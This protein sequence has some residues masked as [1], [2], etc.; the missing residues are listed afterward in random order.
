MSP[1]MVKTNKNALAA[2]PGCR[3]DCPGCPHR[4]MPRQESLNQKQTFLQTRLSTWADRI[5]AICPPDNAPFLYYRKKVCLS[6]LWEVPVWKFGLIRRDAVMD[7]H[8]CPV[9]SHEVRAAIHLFVKSLPHFSAFPLVFYAQSGAQAT[10]V[11]KQQALPDLSWLTSD[12]T[13]QL[14]NTGME[15]LWLHLNPAAGKNVFAK[16]H[17]QLLWGK[18]RSTS[19]DGFLYGPRSFQQPIPAL[20]QQAMEN[21]NAFLL[22][23]K[24][25]L[26]IDL[27][28]GSGIG[29][30]RWTD[31][32]CTVMG[33]EL[34][35]EAVECAAVNA[36][37]ATV[38][39]G[40]CRDRIPQLAQWTKNKKT[41]GSRRLA[42]VN[43]PRPGIE[44]E[45]IQWLAQDYR[46]ARIAYLSC[47]AGTLCRD[48]H[49]LE[50]RGY[51]V[52]RIIP[53]DFFPGTLHVECL[54]LVARK[55][56][57]LPG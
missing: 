23:R 6:A 11:V 22:P 5:A 18:P 13:C 15:G 34:D 27:Y 30:K 39:R 12:F 48:L 35:G 20:F 29:L 57:E 45:V 28:C 33:V 49:F 25:D 53:Y 46:P 32:G 3:D 26:L 17:W 52:Q 16:N 56:A 1:S 31:Q 51:V 19:D 38:L 47:S 10:L 40:R 54:A 42:F 50:A 8:D 9:H 24:N 41:V 14:E 4:R 7:L 43:P 2:A 37:M 36:P 21:A 55:T 44:P